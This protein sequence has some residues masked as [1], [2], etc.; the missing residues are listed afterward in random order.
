ME[1]EGRSDEGVDAPTCHAGAVTVFCYE[2]IN[3]TG[4]N[5]RVG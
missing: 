2:A 4:S 1:Q 5:A 3:W